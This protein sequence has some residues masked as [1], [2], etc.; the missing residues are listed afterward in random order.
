MDNF[1][2]I[3]AIWSLINT[4]GVIAVLI[5]NLVLLL[6]GDLM[7]RKVYENHTKYILEELCTKVLAGIRTIFREEINR[8][9]PR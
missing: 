6:R 2:E 3:N 1:S 9:P 7:P 4:G 8:D 5:I